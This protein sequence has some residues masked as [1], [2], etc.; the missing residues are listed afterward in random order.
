MSAALLWSALCLPLAGPV[1]DDAPTDEAAMMEA[2]TKAAAPG[3]AHKQL[4][5]FAGTWDVKST[6]YLA[7]GAP[8]VTS[9]GTQTNEW[10][11]G[12]RWMNGR[13]EGTFMGMPFEGLSRM[14]YDNV[15]QRYV[16]TWTDTASTG[17][18]TDEGTYDP[19]TKTF[20]YL[21]KVT[22]PV[23]GEEYVSKSVIQVE[24]PDRFT[25]TSYGG[26]D[27]DDLP[28][29]MELVYTRKK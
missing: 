7:P 20:N 5:R 18:M 8:P 3:P 1:Q 16:S 23:S 22:D 4:D 26:P 13:F 24:G 11:L 27:P 28:K 9:A 2:W 17:L 21:G 25:I 19:E 29:S 12:G 15:K 6:I 14:G 10:T